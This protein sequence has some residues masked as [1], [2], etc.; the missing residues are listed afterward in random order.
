MVP[1]VYILIKKIKRSESVWS[2]QNYVGGQGGLVDL[3]EL[4]W[5]DG[6]FIHLWHAVWCGDSKSLEA[7][8]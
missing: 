2:M 3:L 4:R 7:F 5:G 8:L 6:T 1:M